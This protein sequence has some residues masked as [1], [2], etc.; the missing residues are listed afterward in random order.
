[1]SSHREAPE[2][3][4]DP[5]ADSTDVYAFMHPTEPDQVVII[6][7]FIP[8]QQPNGGPNFYEFAD[9]VLYE[10]NVSNTNKCE[11]NVTYQFRFTTEIKGNSFLY[12]NGVIDSI[13]SESWLRPQTYQVARITDA[14]KKKQTATQ[15]GSTF[16]VPPVNVGPRSTPNYADLADSAV[17]TVGDRK[18]FA[19]QR[20]D[21]FYVDLGSIFDLGTLRPFQ[22]LH[23]LPMAAMDGINSVQSYNCHTIAIQVPASDLVKGGRTTPS[24]KDRRN[25]IGIWAT[26][27]RR[28][29]RIFNKTQGKYKDAGPV[30][31]VSRLGNPLVNEVLIPMRNKDQWNASPVN[32]DSDYA[33]SVTTPELQSL[34]PF[35][36]PGVFPNLAA[37]NK[38]RADLAAILLTG[39]PGGVVKDGDGNSIFQNYTGPVQADMLRLNTA[40]PPT[41]PDSASYSIYGVVGGDVGGF[42]N[43][44][45]IEDDVVGIELRAVAGVTIPLVDPSYTPDDAAG[46]L[47]DGTTNTNE[48]LLGTFPFLGHPG[49][50]FQTVPGTTSSEDPS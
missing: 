25:T 29:A 4:K 5:V 11:P 20:S 37:Y 24:F 16:K 48:P 17:T 19:G 42:P 49:G 45:R 7:N 28:K 27:S 6:A 43:G 22:N 47:K 31:Q 40:I 41:D 8:L 35:L 13:D 14:G 3:A 50:G 44:R 15:I 39:I 12:N 10:I 36:Y 38:P 21:A 26:A 32:E 33:D 1:M 9:D 34:L 30:V 46:L 2:I 23:L 18:F